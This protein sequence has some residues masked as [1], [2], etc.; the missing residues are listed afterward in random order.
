MR[1]ALRGFGGLGSEGADAWLRSVGGSALFIGDAVNFDGPA[2]KAHVRWFWLK[3][4]GSDSNLSD[5]WKDASGDEWVEPILSR[6]DDGKRIYVRDLVWFLDRWLREP[7]FAELALGHP[8]GE[9]VENGYMPPFCNGGLM[10]PVHALIT[11]GKGVSDGEIV[12][13]ASVV[14]AFAAAAAASTGPLA[15]IGAIVGAIVGW[16]VASARLIVSGRGREE[17]E[18]KE[19]RRLHAL[20]D[21]QVA[22]VKEKILKA[23][24]LEANVVQANATTQIQ[25]RASA[26]ARSVAA[27]KATSAAAATA[28]ATKTLSGVA[29][30]GLLGI[31]GLLWWRNR[32]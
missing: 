32:K 9:L 15:P 1:L 18:K 5:C 4:G 28:K 31:G 11:S 16:I 22:V 8:I 25:S 23:R 24:V 20:F 29:L 13:Y 3:N 17:D 12:S 6:E 19:A 7:G 27:A 26:Q 10:S 2:V 30:L 14:G 21:G